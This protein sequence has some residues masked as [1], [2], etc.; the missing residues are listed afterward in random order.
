VN[1]IWAMVC[2]RESGAVEVEYLVQIL[3]IMLD[4]YTST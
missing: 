1:G 4:P 3:K 2:V